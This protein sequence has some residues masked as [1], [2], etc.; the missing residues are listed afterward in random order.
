MTLLCKCCINYYGVS[1]HTMTVKN[2]CVGPPPPLEIFE[3]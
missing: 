3:V 2:A 1:H